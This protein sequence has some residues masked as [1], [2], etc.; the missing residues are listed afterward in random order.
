MRLFSAASA[1]ALG[2]AL[3]VFGLWTARA[4]AVP[5]F[6]NGQGV[7]CELCHTTFPGMTRYGMMV[8][9]TNFQI[10]QQHLQDQ[11]LP[12]AVRLYITSYLANH[13]Q[14]GSTTVS[15]LSL[16]SGGFLGRN[17]TY[18][19]E[20]HVI[21]SGQIGDTEQLWASWNG[22]LH[23][24]NSLQVGKFH[25]P[26]PFMPAHAWTLGNYLLA[27]QTTGQNDFNPNDARWGVAFNGMSNEFMYNFSYLTGS[28]PLG[29][30]LDYNSTRNPRAL[31]ANISY[32]GM[33]TPFSIGLVGIQGQAPVH[34]GSTN[35]FDGEDPFTREGLY[36]GYQTD[37]WHFQSMY[38]HG[39]DARPGPAEFN[40]ALNG[41]FFEAERDIG[42]RNHVLVRY[43]VASSDTLNRQ[44]VLDLAHNLQPNLA[45]IGQL[46]VGPQQRPQIGFQIAYAG[47]YEAGRRFIWHQPGNDNAFGVGVVPVGVPL[48]GVAPLTGGAAY[49]PSGDA[50]AGAKLVEA[51]GCTGCHGA[52]FEGAI[53]PKLFGIEHQLD[54]AAIAMHIK[55]PTP[56]MPNFGFTDAQIADIVA[57]LSTLDGG[58][59][60][61]TRPQVSFVPAVPTSTATIEVRF[62]GA[63]PAHVTALPIMQMGNTK[64]H[65]DTI[66]LTPSA[67]DPHLFH[68]V[69]RFTM[70][71]PWEVH[72]E[73]DGKTLDV[74][75]TVGA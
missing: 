32:G 6:A 46:Q 53:G 43:D 33:A 45:L 72:V 44:Y 42:W 40:V 66:V 65:S 63:P 30:A 7:S 2:I 15:D 25:T 57:F 21:D 68:G 58:M 23:G 14:P 22:L 75:L 70:G 50:N 5:V 10:L 20:Q 8:M 62:P 26:F 38:Y 9:M 61:A 28:G 18:Y 67:R 47:P 51:N 74:P 34:F 27:T 3:L 59:G 36:L 69:V 54:P 19:L 29:D 56:P 35:L 16:L 39:F 37:R 55:S 48:H 24:T 52:T 12:I 49:A 17:F 4:D 11:A 1:R 13:Q 41:Y 31:D 60:N 71:G 73:Y 64:M